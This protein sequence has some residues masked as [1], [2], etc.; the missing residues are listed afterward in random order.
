MEE[1]TMELAAPLRVSDAS[2]TPFEPPPGM[3][4]AP[5]GALLDAY[6]RTGV[7]VAARVGPAVVDI[8]L[9]KPAPERMRRQRRAVPEMGGAGSGFIYTPDGFI[10]TNSHVVSGA[11]RIEVSLADGRMFQAELV[12]DDPDTDLAVIRIHGSEFAVAA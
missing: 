3:A 10:L 9:R 4:V 12:G 1:P 2:Q 7:D 5:D 8:A 6:S 11:S